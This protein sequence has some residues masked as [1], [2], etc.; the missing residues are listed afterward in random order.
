MKDQRPSDEDL[1]EEFKAI[2]QIGPVKRTC[3]FFKTKQKIIDLI[4]SQQQ[5]IKY[6]EDAL[7]DLKDDDAADGDFRLWAICILK[8][9]QD[10]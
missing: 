8:G 9:T 4:T 5:R 7:N 1:I 3:N 6:Y 2:R 10:E